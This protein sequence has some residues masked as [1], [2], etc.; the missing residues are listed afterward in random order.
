MNCAKSREI[1]VGYVEGLIEPQQRESLELHLNSC[2]NCR[3]EL[4]QIMALRKRLTAG[5]AGFADHNIETTVMDRIV[6]EQALELRKTNG[7]K[8]HLNFWRLIMKNRLAQLAAAAV[9]I[10]AVLAGIYFITGSP[11]QVTCCTWADIIRPI[12]EAQTA[13]FDIIIGEQDTGALIHDVIWESRIRRT[14][15]GVDEVSIIDL[16]ESKI[17]SIDHDKKKATYIDLKD[18][19]QMPNYM[20]QLRSVI[21]MLQDNPHFVV[22]ELGEEFIDGK[23]VYGFRA[24]HPKVNITI[25]VDPETALPVRLEQEAGQMR[26]IC[27]DMLFD[28]PIDE[29]F[30]SMEAPE[31]YKVE[32]QE[33]N[34]F[35]ST[36]EDFIEG[37]RIQSEFVYDGYFPDDVSVEYYVKQAQT[38][39]DKFDN[40]Q[41][42]DEQQVE[43][44]MKLS[45]G[46][47]F[48]RF[49]KGQGKWYYAGKG[50]ELGDADTPIF[51][52]HPKDSQTWRVIY[53]DLSVEDAAEEQLPQPVEVQEEKSIGFQEWQKDE[54]AGVQTDEWHVTASGDIE[55]YSTVHLRKI[56][57]GVSVMPVKML[58]EKCQLESV[59]LG[60]TLLRT[61]KIDPARYE[62]QLDMDMLSAGDTTMEFA[63]TMPLDTIAKTRRGYRTELAALLWVGSYKLTIVLDEGCGYISIED[64][65]QSQFVPFSVGGDEPKLYFGSCSIAIKPVDE[66]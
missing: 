65:N 58:Y 21:K 48:I 7:K 6:H 49:F 11:P 10:I 24:K 30:F 50:V 15:P 62:V 39:K 54:F 16:A 43:L 29:S 19:P 8:S 42:S 33:M 41:L 27:K 66:Q 61:E 52:Y 63:W 3:A 45:K 46:F 5:G 17:L 56:P 4:A 51:W 31:G 36:E 22:E 13:E 2:P 9:I 59:T 64:P 1:L 53:G 14:M 25:W 23:I 47:M 44:G 60:D 26:I 40:S 38:M 28:V 35:D 34:L 37:L 55:A 32:Q 18:L 12:M 57:Q 20:E